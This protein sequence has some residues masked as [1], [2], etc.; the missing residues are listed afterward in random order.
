MAMVLLFAPAQALLTPEFTRIAGATAGLA[1]LVINLFG[2]LFVLVVN[3]LVGRTGTRFGSRRMWILAGALALS[4]LVVAQLFTTRQWQVGGIWWSTQTLL[5]FQLA[6]TGA[7]FADRVPAAWRGVMCGV[8]GVIAAAGW[9]FSITVTS[10]GSAPLVRWG[11]VAGIAV[12]LAGAAVLLARRPRHRRAAG[13]A[14]PNAPE[15]Q[16]VDWRHPRTHPAFGWAWLVR[17]LVICTF[18]GGAY[19]A[20]YD[21]HRLVS[22]GVDSVFLV[23]TA[24]A[25]ALLATMY[26]VAGLIS[27]EIRRRRYVYAIAAGFVACALAL[28]G[29]ASTSGEG[30]AAAAIALAVGM[31]CF[32]LIDTTVCVRLLYGTDYARSDLGIT[33]PASTLPRSVVP[34]LAPFLV[35]VGG[36]SAL[37]GTLAVLAI[38]RRPHPPSEEMS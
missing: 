6:A 21:V 19:D 36:L 38:G 24:L 11:I 5:N 37:N 15:P 7:L 1:A 4:L 32:T 22:G 23:M 31:G 8:I 33:K 25:V 3:M 30:Y 2:V 28:T 14:G 10:D 9:L 27:D 16:T 29:P 20:I 34:F 35:G 18:A 12:T 13:R 26:A 17:L